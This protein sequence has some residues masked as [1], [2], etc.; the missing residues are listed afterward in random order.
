MIV[1]AIA[2]GALLLPL[3]LQAQSKQVEGCQ[4]FNPGQPKCTYTATEDT[5]TPVSGAA[6]R[7]DWIVILKRGK[8][9]LTYTS[10]ADGSATAT[11]FTI[12]TGDK[13]TAKALTPGSALAIGGG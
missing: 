12:E 9:K 5:V 3:P 10:P 13:L 2:A 1:A 7:G 8:T 4:A 6:G 11:G